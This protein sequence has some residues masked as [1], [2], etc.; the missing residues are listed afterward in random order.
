MRMN[1]RV[2]NIQFSVVTVVL[3]YTSSLPNESVIIVLTVVQWMAAMGE[4]SYNHSFLIFGISR[5]SQIVRKTFI[6]FY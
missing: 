2:F 1:G 3:V 4:H 6:E 5:W